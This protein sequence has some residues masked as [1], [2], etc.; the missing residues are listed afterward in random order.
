MSSGATGQTP[1][2]AVY[3]FNPISHHYVRKSGAVW[4][5]LVK[6][7][8]V[9]DPELSEKLAQKAKT[10]RKIKPALE[11]EPEPEAAPQEAPEAKA[12]PLKGGRGRALRVAKQIVAEN[13]SELDDL[14]SDAADEQLRKLLAKRLAITE[15]ELSSSDESEPAPRPQRPSIKS[16]PLTGRIRLAP[17]AVDRRAALRQTLAKP[18]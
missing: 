17:A 14:E 8:M 10:P 18:L 12:A 11:V 16:G 4:L 7:G 15:S 3:G 1:D 6:A 9:K 13:Q 5:R 2:P